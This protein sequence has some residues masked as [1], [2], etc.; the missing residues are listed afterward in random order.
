MIVNL[1]TNPCC[2]KANRCQL[3]SSHQ[4]KGS[5]KCETGK[6]EAVVTNDSIGTCSSDLYID[7]F[8]ETS[9]TA[10]CGTTGIYKTLSPFR[11]KSGNLKA[12]GKRWKIPRKL[13][14]NMNMD[15][16]KYEIH[17]ENQHFRLDV[18][19]PGSSFHDLRDTTILY[20]FFTLQGKFQRVLWL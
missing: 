4:K 2:N 20:F 6:W 12:L 3:C 8:F 10:S 16:M 5:I 18:T 14:W 19:F 1:L 13:R 9:G 15:S 7:Y 17:I 11:E